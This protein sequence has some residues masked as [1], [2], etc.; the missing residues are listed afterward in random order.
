MNQG[1]ALSP[2]IFNFGLEYAIRGVHAHHERL[3]LNDTHQLVVNADNII[4]L[5]GNVH[6]FYK[7]KHKALVVASE[8]CSNKL[9]EEHRLR[10][11]ENRLLWKTFEPER[12]AVTGKWRRVHKEELNDL[13]SDDQM[14]EMI[15]ACSTYLG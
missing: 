12:K 10:V 1:D 11:F 4:V 3:I 8:T 15:G 2:L 14:R 9:R 13:H 5:G 7:L 6:T